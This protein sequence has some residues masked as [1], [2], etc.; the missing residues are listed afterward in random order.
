MHAGGVIFNL[1]VV[2][3]KIRIFLLEATR[4][5]CIPYKCFAR[6]KM[7]AGMINNSKLVRFQP[8]SHLGLGQ[9]ELRWCD[10]VFEEVRLSSSARLVDTEESVRS[11]KSRLESN[12]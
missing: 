5:R 10:W 3:G 8:L 1:L 6:R 7:L 11:A 12:K 2:H 4:D 9:T